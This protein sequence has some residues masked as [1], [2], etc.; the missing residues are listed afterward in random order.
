MLAAATGAS[1]NQVD[2]L[3]ANRQSRADQPAI[4]LSNVSLSYG[5]VLAAHDLTFDV[6][7]GEFVSLIGPSGCG[8]SSALRAI[9]GL[10]PSQSGSVTVAGTQVRGPRPKDVSFVF[11]DLALYPWRSALRNVEVA[12]QFAGVGRRERRA[13][14][15]EALHAVGLGDVP[16][17]F[18]SQ[19]SGGMQQRVAIARALVSDARIL[20]LDE[21]FAALDEQ[22]RL[23]LGGQLLTLLEEQ[24][25]TVVFV[26]HSLSEAAY[27]SDRI[28][29][30]SPRPATIKDIITV[31]L[32]RPRHPSL[33]RAPEFH[34]LTDRLTSLLFDD[35][36]EQP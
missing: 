27:L 36:S 20:L 16:D 22:T 13:R 23:R 8:K 1:G 19:L 26:T 18:P 7:P 30:M 29:V 24:G 9:G 11:Q 35:E 14:A 34:E 32:D 4:S 25:K 3:D 17:R 15:T 31:P 6:K 33:M 5:S 21:P 12:L 10:L 2:P 28:V